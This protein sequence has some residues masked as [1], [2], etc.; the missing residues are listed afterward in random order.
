MDGSK[1]C[2]VVGVACPVQTARQVVGPAV[3]RAHDAAGVARA[4]QQ[5]MS[6]VLADVVEGPQHTV[7]A[8]H[9][10]D[11]HAR[12]VQRRVVAGFAE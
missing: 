12:D 6:P 2:D 5:G 1:P 10:G 7:I 3:V 11:W 8:A 4:R 9:Y